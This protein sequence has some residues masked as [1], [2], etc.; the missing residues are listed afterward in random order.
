MLGA[1]NERVNDG[2]VS[3]Q[4]ARDLGCTVKFIQSTK[5]TV[6]ISSSSVVGNA[7]VVVAY[8]GMAIGRTL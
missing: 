2:V 3:E 8:R 4:I 1:H 6:E 5:G 7:T